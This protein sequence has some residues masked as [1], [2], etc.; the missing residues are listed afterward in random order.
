M[1]RGVAFDDLLDEKLAADPMDARPTVTVGPGGMATAYGFFFVDAPRTAVASAVSAER[2][3][4]RPGSADGGVTVDWRFAG[5]MSAGSVR[6]RLHVTTEPAAQPSGKKRPASQLP[7]RERRALAE[8]LALG[9]ALHDDFTFDELRSVFRTLARRYHP[10][11]HAGCDEHGKAGLAE[12]F[13]R[14][15][16]AYEVLASHVLR[17]H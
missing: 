6:V 14:A 3:I 5:A 9:G 7:E 12:Q 10:D 16:D 2:R 15:R 8:L 11:R 13:T 1:P 17:V 4:G